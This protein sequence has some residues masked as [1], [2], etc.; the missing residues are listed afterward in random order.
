MGPD[1]HRVARYPEA[2]LLL[3][4]L[5]HASKHDRHPSEVYEDYLEHPREYRLRWTYD[6]W[7]AERENQEMERAR[8]EGKRGN[9][10]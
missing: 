7:A 8:S 1:G 10:P 2:A 4:I 9:R 3:N 6:A 5:A